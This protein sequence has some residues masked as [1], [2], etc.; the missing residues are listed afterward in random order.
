MKILTLPQALKKIK[1]LDPHTAINMTMLKRLIEEDRIPYGSRGTHIVIEINSVISAL[2][3]IL[4]IE[5]TKEIPL[6]RSIRMA[7]VELKQSEQYVHIGEDLIRKCVFDEKIPTI[8]IGNRH[9]VALQSFLEPYAESFVYG[10]NPRLIERDK[11]K[12]D[13]L[14]QMNASISARSGIPKVVRIRS[15][16]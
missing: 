16:K 5:E 1:E 2:N 7:A 3:S 10:K 9:Y 15:K 11:I 13:M 6:L 12:Q 8:S 4:G 14:E